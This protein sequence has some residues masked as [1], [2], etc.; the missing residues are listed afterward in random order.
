MKVK[1]E[2]AVPQNWSE[3]TNSVGISEDLDFSFPLAT[4]L[5]DSLNSSPPTPFTLPT[6]DELALWPN[7]NNSLKAATPRRGPMTWPQ[8]N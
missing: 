6:L 7:T 2:P 5:M 4:S 3:D 8:V 1:D